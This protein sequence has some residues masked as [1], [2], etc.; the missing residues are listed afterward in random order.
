MKETLI[1]IL[2]FIFLLI[3]AYFGYKKVNNMNQEIKIQDSILFVNYEDNNISTNI[4][5]FNKET[6]LK[7]KM[8][9]KYENSVDKDI[10]LD[11]YLNA[12]GDY[13][14]TIGVDEENKELTFKVLNNEKV[15][16]PE[17]EIPSF[18]NEDKIK[19]GSVRIKA[20]TNE[21]FDVITTFYL[22]DLDQNHLSKSSIDFIYNVQSNNC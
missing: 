16:I 10:C 22:N 4:D 3:G 7:T 12:L 17:N 8:I 20:N 9:A 5:F 19:L 18:K 11:I 13:D 14:K 6:I 15:V 2:S 1:T 21:V